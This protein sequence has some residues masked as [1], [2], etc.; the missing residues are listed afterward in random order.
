MSRRP[1]ATRGFSLIEVLVAFSIM[2]LVLGV[3]YRS[4]AGSLRGAVVADQYSRALLWG[5]SLVD[6]R[7]DVP[8]S[9][10]FDAGTTADGFS[11]VIASRP[12]NDGEDEGVV[13]FPLQEV[14]VRVEWSDRGRSRQV[15]LST[16][17]PQARPDAPQR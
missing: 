9:G 8:P 12:L 17:L 10:W 14:T 16:V 2:A 3:V 15:S 13:E 11:W 4:G 5:Q 1:R 7:A 6:S